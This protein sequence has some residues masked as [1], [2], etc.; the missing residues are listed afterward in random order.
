VRPI[1]C[2]DETYA[3]KLYTAF[4]DHPRFAVSNKQK[5]SHQFVVRHYAGD[6]VYSTGGFIE[7]NRDALHKEA[8]DLMAGAR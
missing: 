5:A 4:K 2:R 6:V 1:Y 7:K 8:L 3:N